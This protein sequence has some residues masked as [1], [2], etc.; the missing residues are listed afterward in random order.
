MMVILKEETATIEASKVLLLNNL[1][2][3]C[4]IDNVNHNCNSIKLWKPTNFYET[5]SSDRET[6]LQS[7]QWNNVNNMSELHV[8]FL[9]ETVIQAIEKLTSLSCFHIERPM[10]EDSYTS[11]LPM[12]YDSLDKKVT[13][14]IELQFKR[15]IIPAEYLFKM[16]ELQIL[17]IEESH[18]TVS[19]C[20]HLVCSLQNLRVLNWSYDDETPYSKSCEFPP[21]A[22]LYHAVKLSC[23]HGNC[24]SKKIQKWLGTINFESLMEMSGDSLR[25]AGINHDSL[26]ADEGTSV[27]SNLAING[28]FG[29]ISEILD[30]GCYLNKLINFCDIQ[31]D[32]ITEL[33]LEDG[34]S[35]STTQ[36]L[37]IIFSCKNIK[38]VVIWGI[39]F[40]DNVSNLS[41][42]NT[43]SLPHLTFLDFSSDPSFAPGQ[44]FVDFYESEFLHVIFENAPN[45]ENFCLNLPSTRFT[46]ENL[47][48]ILSQQHLCLRKLMLEGGSLC[49]NIDDLEY[50]RKAAPNLELLGD[51]SQWQELTK[52]ELSLCLNR[53]KRENW[54]LEFKNSPDTGQDL[55]YH[56]LLGLEDDF[57]DLGLD[58]YDDFYDQ[59]GDDDY[60]WTYVDEYDDDVDF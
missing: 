15:V 23:T 20:A 29:P 47:Q 50:I 16:T 13:S 11:L 58:S 2:S 46:S 39:L 56:G 17:N 19:D 40:E 35:T 55:F 8:D 37:T 27:C 51:L 31:G 54:L 43:V 45:I 49:L 24:F 7:L 34:F 53:R 12:L 18:V 10:F 38:S 42:A 57:E 60:D 22:E 4:L 21:F 28:N 6:L 30:N 25:L 36:M 3:I 33:R 44:T 14:L 59:N 52:D 9:S 32:C 48:Y 26:I 41:A 1:H 5:L